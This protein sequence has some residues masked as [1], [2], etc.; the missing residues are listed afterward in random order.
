M[1][2]EARYARDV[3]YPFRFDADCDLAL[4]EDENVIDQALILITFTPAGSVILFLE[5]GCDID[6]SVFDPLE[7]ATQLAIDTS[8]RMAFEKL[9]PRVFLDREFIFDEIPDANELLVVVPYMIKNTN[10]MWNT[11]LTIPRPVGGVE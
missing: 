3:G 4:D 7:P 9:E 11:R 5:L 8:L 10:Q 2:D 1:Y 6:F